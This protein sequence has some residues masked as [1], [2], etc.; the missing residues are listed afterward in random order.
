MIEEGRNY[1]Q[2]KKNSEKD[3][4]WVDKI[5]VKHEIKRIYEE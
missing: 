5:K 4:D 2:K 1:Y 3:N